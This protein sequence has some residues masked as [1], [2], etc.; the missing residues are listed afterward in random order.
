[1]PNDNTSE[2]LTTLDF[3]TRFPHKYWISNWAKDDTYPDGFRYK[4]LSVRAEP[5]DFI[6][7]LLVLERPGGEKT[8]MKHLDV[9]PSAFDRTAQTFVEGLTEAHGL[10]FEP[11]DLSAIRTSEEFE[12]IVTEAGWHEVEP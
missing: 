9:A 3:A 12:R 11:L 1:M 5:D 10:D 7:L 6:E 8:V 4:V 2:P